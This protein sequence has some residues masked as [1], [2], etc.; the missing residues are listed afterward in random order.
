MQKIITIYRSEGSDA[1]LVSDH[2]CLAKSNYSPYL[3][4]KKTPF[5]C[6][7]LPEN[8]MKAP[9]SSASTIVCPK[10]A[11]TLHMGVAADF[12]YVQEKGGTLE[13]VKSIIS[14]WHGVSEIFKRN[15]NVAIEIGEIQIFETVSN[16]VK[17]FNLLNL[18]DKTLQD[19]DNVLIEN[20]SWNRECSSE[21]SMQDRLSEF[22]LWSSQLNDQA[23]LWHLVIQLVRSLDDRLPIVSNH[24]TE[25]GKCALLPK[26]DSF[27]RAVEKWCRGQLS[28]CQGR[29]SSCNA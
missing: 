4:W 16:F 28:R 21:Y 5:K 11:L 20:P 3:S 25:L 22:S 24:G 10:Q 12:R 2:K 18:S 19:V 23:G 9:D 7:F 1:S 14:T 17:P 13:A 6:S 15:F 26:S 27:E 8:S 29:G